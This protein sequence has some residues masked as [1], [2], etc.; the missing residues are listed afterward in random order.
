MK[1]SKE[2]HEMLEVA[3][4]RLISGNP[5]RCA[6]DRKLSVSAVE[7]E[8]G[9]G[10]GS[11]YYYPDIIYKIKAIKKKY[12]SNHNGTIPR[13]ANQKVKAEKLKKEKYREQVAVMREQLSQMATEH[14][15]LTAALAHALNNNN[16][17]KEQIAKI[18]RE[19]IV[20]L[21]PSIPE[22]FN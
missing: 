1:Y 5:K 7:H 6:P 13:T 8:A 16:L 4:L 18:R 14:H 9:L 22:A 15:Q 17:L 10:N 12:Q 20:L 21:K 11:A 3:L 2:T 19:S